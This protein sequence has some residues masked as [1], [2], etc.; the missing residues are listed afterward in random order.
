MYRSRRA[1]RLKRRGLSPQKIVFI[2]VLVFFMVSWHQA[3]RLADWF[4][5]VA[6]AHPH[7]GHISQ[8]AFTCSAFLTDNIAPY[9]PRQ[10]HYIEDLF[11]D[12]LAIPLGLEETETAYP[13]TIRT[14]TDFNATTPPTGP[15]TS[16]NQDNQAPGLLKMTTERTEMVLGDDS[17]LKSAPGSSLIASL[18]PSEPQS[19]QAGTTMTAE[20]KIFNPARVLL[21]G[22]SMMLEGIGPPL[23][24]ELKKN[25]GLTV[26]REGRYGTGLARLDAFDWLAYFQQMLTRY[27]PDI[28]II[29]IGAND[30]QDMVVEGRRLNVGQEE[31]NSIYRQRVA[32]LLSRATALGVPVLWVGLPIMGQEPYGTRVANINEQARKVCMDT[33]GCLFWESWQA[34]SGPAGEY[35]AFLPDSQGKQVRV[36]ARDAIHLT[37]RGGRIMAEKFLKDLASWVDFKQPETETTSPSPAPVADFTP[38]TSTSTVAP[39]A[40]ERDEGQENKGVEKFEGYESLEFKGKLPA[41]IEELSFYSELRQKQTTTLLIKPDQTQGPWPV[42]FLLHGAWDGPRS[43][44]NKVGPKTLVRLSEDLG[45]MLVLPEGEPLGWYVDGKKAKIESFLVQELYPKI[46]SL[47]GVDHLRVGLTGLS[48]GGH[49]ALSFNLKYP[50][51]FQ[52]ASSMSGVLDLEA[53]AGN[54]H[55]LNKKMGLSEALGP[56][57]TGGIN[58]RPHS[59]RS[60]TEASPEFWTGRPLLLTVGLD[61]TLTLE[62]NRAYHRYLKDSGLDHVY[63]EEPGGHN[64]DYWTAMLPVHLKFMNEKLR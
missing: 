63:I 55:S 14:T 36:R 28:V 27:Q 5:N 42:V 24:R 33:S 21:L 6:L 25:K 17:T 16:Q 53:H 1:I 31:W 12:L 49:G 47:P 11:F 7:Q 64:W 43:W 29:T 30:T 38:P 59:V 46:M 32:E 10:L 35:T 48:M 57:G 20:I 41:G 37:E 61:D 45:L 52:A 26:I 23:Q 40:G 50:E 15:A 58:W 39:S 51:L 13:T 9:G 3:D 22:D 60:L 8:I 34:V 44:L 18:P 56:A 54:S 4:D 62:E 2:Y 19:P